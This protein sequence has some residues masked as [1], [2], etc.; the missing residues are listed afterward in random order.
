MGL[1]F[2]LTAKPLEAS[3]SKACNVCLLGSISWGEVTLPVPFWAALASGCNSRGW[4]RCRKPNWI[5]VLTIRSYQSPSIELIVSNL[6]AHIGYQ[7]PVQH[8]RV[9]TE[10][11]LL[12][13]Q[14]HRFHRNGKKQCCPWLPGNPGK[15]PKNQLCMTWVGCKKPIVSLQLR[16]SPTYSWGL[17]L[18]YCFTD[19]T[20]TTTNSIV[21]DC[22]KIWHWPW[23]PT[24]INQK[25]KV[26]V[27]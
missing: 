23:F 5:G 15:C 8:F 11:D 14:F 21:H 19:F 24:K 7:P 2:H 1:Y 12:K 6:Q 3:V 10:R 9:F 18:H 17:Y 25:Y 26:V 22:C 20:E 27:M 13:S 4:Q 16:K